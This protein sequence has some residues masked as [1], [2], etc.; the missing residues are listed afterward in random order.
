MK[1][2]AWIIEI[3]EGFLG[4]VGE[5]ELIHIL[6]DNPQLFRIPRTPNYC[7]QVFI[8]QNR[9]IPVLNPAKK[10]LNIEAQGKII[11]IFAYRNPKTNYIEYGA[12]FIT[13]TPSRVEV[14]DEQAVSLP[15]NLKTWS[16][17]TKC[18]FQ[19]TDTQNIIPILKIEQLFEA[20]DLPKEID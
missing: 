11:A 12:L 14:S 20:Q 8:W 2:T 13:D 3:V 10:L 19:D 9:I 15:E 1:A 5:F 4:A 16:F 18:C 6:P 7:Q 17:Y